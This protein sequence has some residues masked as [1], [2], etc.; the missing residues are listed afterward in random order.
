[1]NTLRA[2]DLSVLYDWV[3]SLTNGSLIDAL[4]AHAVYRDERGRTR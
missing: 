1:M 2:A 3:S 4:D